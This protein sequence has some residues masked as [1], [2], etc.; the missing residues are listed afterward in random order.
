MLGM[1]LHLVAAHEIVG[2][3]VDVHTPSRL[4]AQRLR[5]TLR[6][7][8]AFSLVGATLAA[9]GPG[10]LDSWLDTGH[11]DGCGLSASEWS[12]SSLVSSPSPA[13]ACPDC[14]A[15]HLSSLPATQ[16]G[17]RGLITIFAGWYGTA[18]DL[19]VAAVAVMVGGFAVGQA[20]PGTG[21]GR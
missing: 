11:A 16:R 1:E 8:A 4:A 5:N 20:S 21:R 13:H 7:N 14:S 6:L 9:V 10:R 12:P 18:G 2:P 17:P 3:V 19:V 15:G